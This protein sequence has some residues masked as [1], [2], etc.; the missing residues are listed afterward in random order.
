MRQEL[1]AGEQF[2]EV[3]TEIPPL[4]HKFDSTTNDSDKSWTV[5]NNEIWKINWAHI[6]FTSTAT[7]G[8]RSV[9]IEITDADSNDV[10]DVHPGSV[11]A[12]SNTYHYVYLQGIYRETSFTLNVMQVPIP[13][14]FYLQ[15][16][17]TIRFYDSAAID[18]AADDMTVSFQ[19]KK[20]TI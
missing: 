16:G 12:A 8:D 4:D 6:I 18:A 15:P 14:D 3:T 2:S 13:K 19:F 20:Y 10:L 1:R 11:Q 17:W 7:V 5:P 9:E